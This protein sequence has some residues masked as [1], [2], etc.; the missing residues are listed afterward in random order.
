VP[1]VTRGD[2]SLYYE[3][4]GKGFPVLFH[5]GGGGD[6]RMWHLAGYLDRLAGY[7]HLVLDHRGHG[8][9]DCPEELD[10]HRMGEYVADVVAVLDDAQVERAVLLGYS[11]GASVLY[12][13]AATHPERCA[14]LIG[15]GSVPEPDDDSTTDSP[16][17]AHLREVGV[18]ALMEEFAAAESEPAP[19]WLIDNLA[20]T[21]TEMFALLLEAWAE[22]SGAWELF[23]NMT[24]PT[25]LVAGEEEQVDGAADRAAA[26]LPNGRAAVLP[27][28]GHLQAFWHE[29]ITGPLITDFLRSLGL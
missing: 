8:R 9:S 6:G 26:Q 5:T 21:E 23:P 19:A 2:V 15:I 24:A 10:A 29:E 3:D 4:G 20:T 22:L 13:V 25:L 1:T 14:A 17:A 28:Y 12:R 7:R 11:G 18:R 27:G 16:M